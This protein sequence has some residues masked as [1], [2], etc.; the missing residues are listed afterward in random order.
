MFDKRITVITKIGRSMVLETIL[1]KYKNANT[2][3]FATYN[4]G[5]SIQETAVTI[6]KWKILKLEKELKSCLKSEYIGIR[7]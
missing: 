3:N 7:V 6:K 1:N 5:H 2:N 4:M